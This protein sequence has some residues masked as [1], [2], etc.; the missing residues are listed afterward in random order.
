MEAKKKEDKKEGRGR[1]RRGR[2]EGGEVGEESFGLVLH[3][4]PRRPFPKV[5]V[6]FSQLFQIRGNK[7]KEWKRSARGEKSV[8]EV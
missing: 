7:R 1:R 4:F 2:R 3:V 8:E 5:Y 6:T